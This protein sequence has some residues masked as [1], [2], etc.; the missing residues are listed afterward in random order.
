MRSFFF[1]SHLAYE[2]RDYPWRC[3]ATG[4]R[5]REHDFKS[6]T[7]GLRAKWTR[8]LGRNLNAVQRFCF[9]LA[10]TA[11]PPR[12]SKSNELNLIS[13]SHVISTRLPSARLTGN[14]LSSWILLLFYNDYLMIIYLFLSQRFGRPCFW[15]SSAIIKD[16]WKICAISMSQISSWLWE[17]SS[18]KFRERLE[19]IE[20]RGW[21]KT[22]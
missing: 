16:S 9:L 2:W 1:C 13:R 7:R 21:N 8:G 15:T 18:T 20:I 19:E 12:N 10:M 22:I 4:Q 17:N 6:S 3:V 14:L 5:V 11:V